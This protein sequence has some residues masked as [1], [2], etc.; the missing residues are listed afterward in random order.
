M[1]PS[2]QRKDVH[3]H[4]LRLDL[5]LLSLVGVELFERVRPAI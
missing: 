1:V 5:L 3:P 2:R 4:D